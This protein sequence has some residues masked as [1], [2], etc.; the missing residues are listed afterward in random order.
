MLLL[1]LLSPLEMN[2][3]KPG[4]SPRTSADPPDR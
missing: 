3:P 2:G 4:G 1:N